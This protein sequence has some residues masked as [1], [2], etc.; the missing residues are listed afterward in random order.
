MPCKRPSG[1]F[2]IVFIIARTGRACKVYEELYRDNVRLLQ[3]LAG[4][5][6]PACALNRAVDVDDLVQA[7]FFGLIRAKETFDENKG[8]TWA[9]W[10]AWH[11]KREFEK[12]LGMR[13]GR[14][15]SAD[16]GAVSLDQPLLNKGEEQETT[17]G[18]LLED[19]NL[20]EADEGL[21]RGEIVRTVRERVDAL[22]DER[23][24]EIVRRSRLDGETLGQ[25][26]QD[27]GITFQQAAQIRGKAEKALRKDKYLRA[28]ADIDERTRYYVHKGASAFQ[29]DHTSVVEA[30]VIWREEQRERLLGGESVP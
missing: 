4:R 28:L 24:R 25:V 17:R 23:G 21:L 19:E 30:A 16:A 29:S 9:G 22:E 1:G 13:E 6:A 3:H 14:F 7:G 11:V 20:P 8:K 18:E 15:A 26:A 5:Y 10:A 2:P 27:M 12:A